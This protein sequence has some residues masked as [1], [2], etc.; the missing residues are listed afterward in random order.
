MSESIKSSVLRLNELLP[1]KARQDRHASVFR[2]LHRAVIVSLVVRGR[3]PSR[4]EIAAQ[5]GEMQVDAA[6][7]R[8]GNDDL[9]VLSADRRDILLFELI[10]NKIKVRST[11]LPRPYPLRPEKIMPWMK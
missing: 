5:V 6:L 10:A 7:A 8:L 9:V 3:P 4:A 2:A 11:S 1:L